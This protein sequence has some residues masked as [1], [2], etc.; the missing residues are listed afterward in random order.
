M[1]PI[2][3]PYSVLVYSANASNVDTVI[4]NGKLIVSDKTLLT[5]D[6]EKSRAAIKDFSRKVEAIAETL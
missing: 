6:E 5:Y 4:V 1:Q 2:F 3:D